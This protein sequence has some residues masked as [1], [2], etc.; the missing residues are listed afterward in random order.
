MVVGALLL[1]GVATQ[2]VSILGV[3]V[4]QDP[5]DRLHF[6]SPANTVAPIAIAAAI[7]VEEGLWPVGV[8]VMLVALVL[9]VTNPLVT[10][11]TARAGRVREHGRWVT[12]P[13]EEQG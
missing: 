5:Y 9:L 13:E 6:T 10:H 2:L 7:V 11:A 4:M 12:R 1:I 8:K 3:C